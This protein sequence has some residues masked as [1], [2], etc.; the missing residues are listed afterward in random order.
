MKTILITGATDGIGLALAKAYQMQAVRLLLIGRRPLSALTDPIF[1]DATYCQTNLA[2]ENCAAELSSWLYEHSISEI[3][4]VIHNAAIGYVGT[5]AAQPIDNLRDQIK[6]NLWAPMALSHMLFPLVARA[7]GKFVFISSVA[8]AFAGPDYATY[9][10]TK[11]ALEGFVRS[12]R[13]ELTADQSPVRLQII[14]P[15]ATR[16]NMHAKSGA[17][18]AKLRAERFPSATQVAHQIVAAVASNH[19]TVTLGLA[20]QVLYTVGTIGDTLLDRMMQQWRWRTT[21]TDTTSREQRVVNAQREGAPPGNRPKPHCV[22][23]G[24]ADGIGRA[25]AE[26]FGAAGYAITGIDVDRPR[27]E[28][29]QTALVAAGVDIHFVDGDLSATDAL[30][31]LV[32]ALAERPPIDLFIHNAGI[33]AVGPF[34]DSNLARQRAVF[35]INCSAPLL[36]TALLLR[37]HGMAPGASFV[38]I[39][40]LSRFMSYPG[41]ALYAATKDALASYARSLAVAAVSQQSHVL[42]VFPGPTRTAHARRYSP[43]NRRE[44]S[45]MP[46]STVAQ[47]ILAAVHARRRRLIPGMANHGAA[48]LGRLFPSLAEQLMRRTIYDRLPRSK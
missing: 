6:I 11:V 44:A 4:L 42:T 30:P 46:P 19:H 15:G 41:A 16:T 24:A 31:L 23:T 18:P 39:S 9:T 1:S 10:A 45:R 47:L 17:D 25:L 7:R 35:D 29:L 34:V 33:S 43:D 21:V 22:I 37:Q 28:A 14:R 32:A 12:W 48:I 27:A 20:N 8:T 40:S 13:V 5:I 3:D 38:F 2:D 26:A 36:L